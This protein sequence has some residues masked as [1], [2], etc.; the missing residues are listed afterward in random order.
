MKRAE[1]KARERV[2]HAEQLLEGSRADAAKALQRA[3]RAV[4]SSRT[5]LHRIDLLAYEAGSLLMLVSGH[6]RWAGIERR[7]LASA[8][9]TGRLRLAMGPGWPRAPDILNARQRR[10]EARRRKASR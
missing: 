7:T 3:A 9:R 6:A 10:R 1:A 5:P 8:K 4:A 2:A